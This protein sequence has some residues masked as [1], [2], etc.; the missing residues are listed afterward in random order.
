MTFCRFYTVLPENVGK[1]IGLQPI[2]EDDF[3]LADGTLIK[4]KVSECHVS[5]HQDEGVTLI[6]F[7]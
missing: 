5:I 3:T 2:R 6:I 1:K 7:R 4:R